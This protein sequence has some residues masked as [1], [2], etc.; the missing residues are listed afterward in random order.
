MFSI[1]LFLER[2]NAH[3]SDIV[4]KILKYTSQILRHNHVVKNVFECI[5]KY[6]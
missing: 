2:K 3:C 5:F 1:H 4:S 6:K